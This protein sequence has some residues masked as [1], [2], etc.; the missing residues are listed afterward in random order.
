MPGQRQPW[1]IFRNEFL[2]YH[3]SA[4]CITLLPCSSVRET[5]QTVDVTKDEDEG[6]ANGEWRMGNEV[7]DINYG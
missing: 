4:N 7:C 5:N 2:V 6:M 1:N 3:F